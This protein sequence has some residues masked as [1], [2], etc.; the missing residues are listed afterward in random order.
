MLLKQIVFNKRTR[1]SWP[2]VG[3]FWQISGFSRGRIKS[4]TIFPIGIAHWLKWP[5]QI[6]PKK[7]K[8]FKNIP[9]VPQRNPYLKTY[10]RVPKVNYWIFY[11]FLEKSGLA[12]STNANRKNGLAFYSTPWEPRNL[13]KPPYLWPR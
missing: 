11:F 2:Q 13:P 3:E 9:L 1:S 4:E 8:F 6:F 7:N 12:I 10:L 5:N